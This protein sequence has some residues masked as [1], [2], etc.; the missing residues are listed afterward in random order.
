MDMTSI[1]AAASSLKAAADVARA[2]GELHTMSEVQGKVIE[3]QSKILAAQSSA[4]AAQS[5]HALMSQRVSE[6]ESEVARVKEWTGEKT[7]YSL[8]K[9]WD[10]AVV[11]ALRESV[12]NGEPPHWICTN[13]YQSGRKSILNQVWDKNGTSI[14]LCP[15]CKAS[16]SYAWSGRFEFSYGK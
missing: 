12:S 3:L 14:V 6:L 15:V 11:Y 2:L 5:E 7:R 9:P 16:A 1:A 8:I 4:L 10:G 13:C